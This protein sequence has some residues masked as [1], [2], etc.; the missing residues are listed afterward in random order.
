MWCV[1]LLRH[2]WQGP[3]PTMSLSPWGMTLTRYAAC[4]VTNS[5]GPG[6]VACG[7]VSSSCFG[8]LFLVPQNTNN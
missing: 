5:I 4:F 6:Q 7:G 1:F 8:G 2:T 3:G